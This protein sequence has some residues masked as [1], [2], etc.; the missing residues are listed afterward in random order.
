MHVELYGN[1]YTIFRIILKQ[2]ACYITSCS[3]P[4][5][6]LSSHSNKSQSAPSH[7]DLTRFVHTAPTAS[8]PAR[9]TPFLAHSALASL[10]PTNPL[11]TQGL[12]T[13]CSPLRSA[14]A[15][16]PCLQCP[17]FKITVLPFLLYFIPRGNLQKSFSNLFCEC[18]LGLMEKNP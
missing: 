2:R 11:L 1:C 18:P 12:A 14:C 9:I 3:K 13:D 16:L 4:S 17:A 6:G 10:S 5:S 8:N 7:F 15:L